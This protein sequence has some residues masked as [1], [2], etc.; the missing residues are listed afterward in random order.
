M[1]VVQQKTAMKISDLGHIGFEALLN[2][3]YHKDFLDIP[4]ILETPYVDKKAP[5]LEE[6]DMIRKKTF[7]PELVTKLEQK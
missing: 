5:Y 4:K 6:I 2:V 7:D 1:K 3:V